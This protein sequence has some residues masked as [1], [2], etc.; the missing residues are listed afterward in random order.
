MYNVTL[1]T[2]KFFTSK[3]EDLEE[4]DEILSNPLCSVINSWREKQIDSIYDEGQ[5][6]K[7]ETKL[8]LVVTWETKTL[9]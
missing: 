6:V 3:T 2:K 7:T 1:K 8:V 4:Y 9:L 5:L